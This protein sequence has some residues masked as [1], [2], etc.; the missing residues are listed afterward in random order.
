MEMGEH[1]DDIWVHSRMVRQRARALDPLQ[2]R[3]VPQAVPV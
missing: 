2:R 1:L 3:T